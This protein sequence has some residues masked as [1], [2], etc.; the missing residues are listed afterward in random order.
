[1]PAAES[2]SVENG[3]ER[4]SVRVPE[5][6]A[7]FWRVEIIDRND[8]A[9]TGASVQLLGTPR[10]VVFRAEPDRSYRLLMGHPRATAAQFDMARLTPAAELEAAPAAELGPIAANPAWADPAPWTERNPYLPWIALLLAAAILIPLA[11]R[12]LRS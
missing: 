5:A 1:M 8:P 3:R 6:Q 11:M 7:R 2:A 4:L 9:L 12:S 10:R